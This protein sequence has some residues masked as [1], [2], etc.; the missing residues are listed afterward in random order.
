MRRME[1]MEG[2]GRLI[3][4]LPFSY[5]SVVHQFLLLSGPCINV[6]LFYLLTRAS[7]MTREPY[8]V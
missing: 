5:S 3:E 6:L 7:L 4:M 1:K 8:K 2:E